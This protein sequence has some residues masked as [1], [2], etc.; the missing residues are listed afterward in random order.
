MGW[1]PGALLAVGIALLI[2]TL[3]QV[4]FPGEAP[5][6]AALRLAW[7]LRGE[8]VGECP[9]PTA[10]QL[11]VLPPHMRN[12]DACVGPLPPYRL[13][14]WL[15]GELKI[16]AR[17]EGGGARGDSPLY[18]NRELRLDSGSYEVRADFRREEGDAP[19]ED[20]GTVLFLETRVELE[21]GTVMLLTRAGDTGRLELRRP[22]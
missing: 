22:R 19:L 3:S 13:R 16:D 11:A 21:A 14:L 17:V 5:D 15:D 20:P 12:P 7:R 1:I 8:E 6:E 4:P 2:G 18:V 10:E 9:R